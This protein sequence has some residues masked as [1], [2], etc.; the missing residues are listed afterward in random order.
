MI[1][2]LLNHYNLFFRNL[3]EPLNQNGRAKTR[4]AGLVLTAA[5]LLSS[6]SHHQKSVVQP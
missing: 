6:T 5:K 3:S 2:L 1:A 4:E